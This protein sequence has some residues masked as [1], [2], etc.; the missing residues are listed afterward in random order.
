MMK[1]GRQKT[2][3]WAGAGPTEWVLARTKLPR[4]QNRPSTSKEGLTWRW[5]HITLSN[6]LAMQKIEELIEKQAI[7]ADFLRKALGQAG[8]N[9]DMLPTDK[10]YEWR[11]LLGHIQGTLITTE[12]MDGWCSWASREA[13]AIDKQILKARRDKWA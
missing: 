10:A 11:Q 1:S 13:E 8:P 9:T 7:Q 3:E 6:L 12:A 5:L 2:P 4:N